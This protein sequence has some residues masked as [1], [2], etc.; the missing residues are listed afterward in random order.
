MMEEPVRMKPDYG[1]VPFEAEEL[2]DIGMDE[3]QVVSRFVDDHRRG[4]LRD[5]VTAPT[6]GRLL[7]E[8]G[9]GNFRA[10]VGFVRRV[11]MAVNR[12]VATERARGLA[13]AADGLPAR[14]A[15]AFARA[16]DEG[17]LPAREQYARQQVV[18]FTRGAVGDG[19]LAETLADRVAAVHNV[20]NGH[21]G[22]MEGGVLGRP[23]IAGTELDFCRTYMAQVGD[24]SEEL[25]G[26]AVRFYPV[27]DS[28]PDMWAVVRRLGAEFPGL[29]ATVEDEG[30]EL[31]AIVVRDHARHEDPVRDYPGMFER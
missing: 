27:P 15:A 17:R 28:A 19:P 26:G 18:E 24:W 4:V 10:D 11:A 6:L 9:F 20:V 7:V 3:D 30:T 29:E 13:G 5:Q 31:A 14:L 25:E 1:E 23:L 16:V 2:G 21:C 12:R 8:Y 22:L